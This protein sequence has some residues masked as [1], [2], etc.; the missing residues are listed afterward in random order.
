MHQNVGHVDRIIRV[1]V[2]AILAT[3][4]LGAGLSGVALV[5]WMLMPFVVL[6]TGFF[7][8]CPLYARLGINTR[9]PQQR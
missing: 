6:A 3:V 8:F 2:A 4:V 9:H 5:A 1:V 7:G